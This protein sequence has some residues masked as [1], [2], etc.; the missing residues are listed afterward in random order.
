MKP[1]VLAT[2]LEEG[3]HLSD[4]YDGRSPQDVCGDEVRNDEGDPPFGRID[5]AKALAFS[6]NTVYTRLACDVG[7]KDVVRLVSA[8]PASCSLRV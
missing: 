1:Y 8:V 2:A 6:V 3:K 7:P 4:R 5:L